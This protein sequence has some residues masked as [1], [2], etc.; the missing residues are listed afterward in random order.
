MIL[1]GVSY[2]TKNKIPNPQRFY[3]LS[4]EI[5]MKLKEEKKWVNQ[6]LSYTKTKIKTEK[7]NHISDVTSIE[8]ILYEILKQ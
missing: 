3:A 5:M 4:C 1:K 7:N 8:S 6:L 2:L